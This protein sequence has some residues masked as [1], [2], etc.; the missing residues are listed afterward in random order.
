MLVVNVALI[1]WVLIASSVIVCTPALSITFCASPVPS[2]PSRLLD[3][4]IEIVSVST[5]SC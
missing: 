2:A 1:G 3:H 5:P 4:M